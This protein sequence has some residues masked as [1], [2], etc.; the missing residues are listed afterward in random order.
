MTIQNENAQWT[1]RALILLT[2]ISLW[3]LLYL[4]IV[5]LDL[6]P[7]EA[8]YWDWSRRLAFGYF[9]KPPLI[10]WINALTTALFGATSVSVRLPAVV[11]GGLGL[12][13][14]FL[15]ARRIYSAEVGF[16]TLVVW[17][18]TPATAALGLIMATDVLL[19]C[20]W[21]LALWTLWHS[22]ED[23][24]FGWKLA[25]A[26]L[27]GI[28]TLG[29]QMMLVFPLLMLIYL[30]LSPQD[31]PQLKRPWPWLVVCGSLLFL[32]PP[33]W[34]NAQHDW[35]TFR[36]TAH[37]IGGSNPDMLARLATF[38]EFVGSQLGLL[39]PLSWLLLVALAFSLLL[40][41]KKLPRQTLYLLCFNL[42][43]LI[44]FFLMSFK[45]SINPNW[46]AVFYPAGMILLA[47]WGRGALNAGRLDRLRRFFNPAWKLG[48]IL[49]LAGYLLPFVSQN[50]LDLGRKDPTWRIRGWQEA[51]RVTAEILAQQPHS[52]KTFILGIERKHA[53]ESAF[54]LPDH[55]RTYRWAG[56][57]PVVSSQYEV[58]P[59]PFD[60]IGWDALIL[61]DSGTPLPPKLLERF[62]RVI[63][64]QKKE[65]D[66]GGSLPRR[67]DYYL[68]ENLKSWPQRP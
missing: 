53:A 39:S 7:D 30:L 14:L 16:W 8:Y 12:W 50:L 26:L 55:P 44:G 38:S 66:L 32:I 59:G 46:P 27:I 67:L 43:G 52:D 22:L 17:L 21:S 11:L 68:G 64:L 56:D 42:I 1:R 47:A 9:S 31:R 13:G 20:C 25:T 18:A 23:D 36:H 57:P 5:P 40:Q 41:L 19:I 29:K 51:G 15:A 24:T 48:L 35:I 28:G 54:Y 3:R 45:K 62:S 37:N 60:R 33:L 6:G 61:S 58:W 34:W 65:I 49:L 10:A 63:P 4:F 2:A